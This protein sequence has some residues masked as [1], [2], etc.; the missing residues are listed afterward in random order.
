M[1]IREVARRAGVGIGTVSR[2]L[3]G[4]PSVRPEVR[5]RVLD[6]VKAL[7]YVPNVH[8]QRMWKRKSNTICFLLSN[9]EILLSLHGHIFRGVEEFAARNG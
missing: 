4:H 6:M 2:V 5:Q 7:G 9:R 8:A 3:N 1:S